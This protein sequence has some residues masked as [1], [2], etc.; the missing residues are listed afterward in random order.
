MHSSTF[1]VCRLTY[2]QWPGYLPWSKQIPTLDFKTPKGPITRAKLAKNIAICIRRFAEVSEM[3]CCSPVLAKARSSLLKKSRWR[4]NP[5]EDGKSENRISGWRILFWYPSTKY[6]KGVGNRSFVLLVHSSRLISTF[7]QQFLLC[8][9]LQVTITR[10]L[11]PLAMLT[12]NPLTR[13][14]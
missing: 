12:Y 9:Y 1:L 13:F 4:R 14:S 7:F 5:T 6:P 10:R 3:Q 2:S 8:D 11:R